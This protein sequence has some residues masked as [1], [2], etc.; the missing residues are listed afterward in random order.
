MPR[1]RNAD[2]P[3]CKEVSLPGSLLDHADR[4]LVDPTDGKVPHGRYSKLFIVLLAQWL[5]KMEEISQLEADEYTK[6][7]MPGGAP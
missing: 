4:L 1:P 7:A 5:V 3:R 2:R 6:A